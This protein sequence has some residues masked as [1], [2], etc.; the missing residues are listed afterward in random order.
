MHIPQP[1]PYRPER[2]IERLGNA[3]YDVV[4]AAELPKMIL[5]FRNDH[6]AAAIGL[7]GPQRLAQ[8]AHH[9]DASH[10]GVRYDEIAFIVDRKVTF[11]SIYD[12]SMRTMIATE[13]SMA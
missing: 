2:T 11:P 8:R 6:W 7:D 12:P 3:F 13:L 4:K 5:R 1:S 9:P 10:A